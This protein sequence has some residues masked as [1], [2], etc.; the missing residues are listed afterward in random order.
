MQLEQCYRGFEIKYVNN[1][2]QPT[3]ETISPLWK[4][5]KEEKVPQAQHEIM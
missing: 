3:L 2:Q 4:L 1:D 5:R